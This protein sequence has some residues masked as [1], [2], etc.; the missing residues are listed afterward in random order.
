MLIQYDILQPLL[1]WDE[2]LHSLGAAIH[3]DKV[4]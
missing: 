1:G 4:M 2:I 3:Q